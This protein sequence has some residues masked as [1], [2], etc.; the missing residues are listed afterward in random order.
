VG[1]AGESGQAL[2]R[3]FRAEPATLLPYEGPA[4][5]WGANSSAWCSWVPVRP[6]LTSL[7][8]LA[9]QKAK[10]PKGEKASKA[11]LMCVD[12]SEL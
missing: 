6:A 3:A 8:K 1:L 9:R 7:E 10:R 2:A 12:S 11:L 4:W 5:P